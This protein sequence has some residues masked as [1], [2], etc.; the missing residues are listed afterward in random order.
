MT[1]S[2]GFVISL[3]PAVSSLI[4]YKEISIFC[5]CIRL[6]PS[7]PSQ[8]K[9]L[10]VFKQLVNI[11][12]WK[13]NAST[14]FAILLLPFDG[15]NT[16]IIENSVNSLHMLLHRSFPCQISYFFFLS[17]LRK[18]FKIKLHLISFLFFFFV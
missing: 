11:C 1:V 13:N 8:K 10:N 4:N 6:P 12:G 14:L 15:E 17:V 2:I 5:C 9:R 7:N 18:L 3:R 16:H